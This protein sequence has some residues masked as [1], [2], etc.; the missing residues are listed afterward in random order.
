MLLS[1]WVNSAGGGKYVLVE[2]CL[3]EYHS[4]WGGVLGLR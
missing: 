1:L 3:I 2:L 4:T